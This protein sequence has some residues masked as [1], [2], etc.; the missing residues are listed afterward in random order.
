[1]VSFKFV[2]SEPQT[3]KSY[4]LEVDQA[5]A[6]GLLGKKIG[7]EFNGDLI[8]LNGYTLQITG[9]TDKDGFPMHPQ[10]AGQVKK[11]LL[12]SNPP[13]FH[14]TKKGERRRKLIRGNVLSA[15][16]MQVNVKV[17]KKGEKPIEQIVPQKSKPEKKEESKEEKKIEEKKEEHK[18][19]K[20]AK[21]PKA[22]EKAGGEQ[23]KN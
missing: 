10:V 22:E 18:E 19:V 23:N 11:K 1:M 14:P 13:G 6:I 2:I 8:G 17:T 4:Q 9:G 7:E 20:E 3:R 21:Q 15:D 5:K 16:I 12:L